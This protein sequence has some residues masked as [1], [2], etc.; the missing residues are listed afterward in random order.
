MCA[1]VCYPHRVSNRSA[2][3]LAPQDLLRSHEA[4]ALGLS[5]HA[6]IAMRTDGRIAWIRL[7]DGTPRYSRADVQ[8]Q[9]E[10]LDICRPWRRRSGWHQDGR[11]RPWS[12]AGSRAR[13]S[14]NQSNPKRGSSD[15]TFAPS[16][17]AHPNP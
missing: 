13:N 5:R 9:V 15:N 6:L 12:R 2:A 14:P 16:A 4:E 10:I 17:D 1:R 3:G 11:P 8:L 7:E